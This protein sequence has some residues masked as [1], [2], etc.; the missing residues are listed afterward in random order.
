MGRTRQGR[1]ASVGIPENPPCQC[2]GD[3]LRRLLLTT[4]LLS[5]LAATGSACLKGEPRNT[6]GVSIINDT[7]ETVTVVVL[8]PEP[9]EELE[10]VTY[11]PGESS[12]ENR[13]LGEGGC[14]RA[15]MVAVAEDGREVARQPAPI[16]VDEEWRIGD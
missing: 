10:L 7:D 4:V 8:Y 1:K 5:L 11:G 14:T 2:Y 3:P 9:A 15:D 13:M 12:V 16:C 6:Q